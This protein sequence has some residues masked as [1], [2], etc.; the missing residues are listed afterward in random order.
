[1]AGAETAP[2]QHRV[3]RGDV[4]STVEGVSADQS[5]VAGEAGFE[6]IYSRAGSNLGAIPWASLAANRS[7]VAWLDRQPARRG[8]TCLV[9]GCGLGD[10]AEELARRGY[11]V[12]AFDVSPTAIALCRKRFPGSAVDYVVE[13]LFAAPSVWS[14]SFGLVVEIRTLQSLP[15]S[16]RREAARAIARTV[17]PGGQ[18]FVRC[19]AREADEPLTSRPW[20]LTRRELQAF[21]GGGLVETQICDEP[22]APGPA[23]MFTAIYQRPAASVAP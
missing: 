9:I 19:A 21:T 8:A 22:A 14:A 4:F 18:V 13:D 10:D 17:E 12:T 15:P 23:R 7:L 3:R 6:E 2:S 5:Q 20:P 16:R 11:R 1:V